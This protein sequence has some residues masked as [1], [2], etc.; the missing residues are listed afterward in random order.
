MVARIYHKLNTIPEHRVNRAFHIA[1]EQLQF[2]SHAEHARSQVKVGQ[3]W[4][5]FDF[6]HVEFST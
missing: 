5:E 4:G 1:P 6:F 3:S 2:I